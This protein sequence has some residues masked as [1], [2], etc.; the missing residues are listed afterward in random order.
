VGIRTWLTHRETLA[1]DSSETRQAGRVPL[2]GRPEQERRTRSHGSRCRREPDGE[3]PR[4]RKLWRN[5]P[6]SEPQRWF[7]NDGAAVTLD[8]GHLP[9]ARCGILRHSGPCYP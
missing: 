4:A 2:I 1:G 6:F 8:L 5:S 7:E 3:Q 9:S